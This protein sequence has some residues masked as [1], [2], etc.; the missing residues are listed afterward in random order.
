MTVE[1][2]CYPETWNYSR[3]FDMRDHSIIEF[4]DN[5]PDSVSKTIKRWFKRTQNARGRFN[6]HKLPTNWNITVGVILGNEAELEISINHSPRSTQTIIF[7]S[8]DDKVIIKQEGTGM[9]RT[10]QVKLD[11]VIKPSTL[12]IKRSGDLLY[13]I[14]YDRND[15]RS[16]HEEN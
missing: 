14:L 7:T 11:K 4:F 1:A 13:A 10:A 12:D 5:L 15:L 6:L 9:Y 2:F 3:T 8:R 16:E